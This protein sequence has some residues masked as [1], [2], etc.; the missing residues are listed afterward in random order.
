M[1]SNPEEPPPGLLA[2]WEMGPKA[3][4]ELLLVENLVSRAEPV[5]LLSTNERVSRLGVPPCF[6]SKRPPP[7]ISSEFLVFLH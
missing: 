4:Q 1:F 2:D 5:R 7:L 6:E 3:R